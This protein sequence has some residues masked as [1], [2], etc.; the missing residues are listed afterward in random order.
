[1][2]NGYE[3][4]YREEDG[5][6]PKYD[7]R[8]SDKLAHNL[9]GS[10]KQNHL[11][12]TINEAYANLIEQNIGKKFY[13]KMSKMFS[14]YQYLYNIIQEYSKNKLLLDQEE[15]LFK[16]DYNH[17]K[18][19][20]N[21]KKEIETKIKDLLKSNKE[22]KSIKIKEYADKLE[23]LE[24]EIADVKISLKENETNLK[25][26]SRTSFLSTLG[27]VQNELGVYSQKYCD[28]ILKN[29]INQTKKYGQRA[30][31]LLISPDKKY[32]NY[33]D[34]KEFINIIK[35]STR[36]NDSV[37]INDS[38]KF[39]VYLQKTKLNGAYSVFERINNALGVDCGAN[40][41]VVEV[42][43]QK[44]EDI[45]QALNDAL[46]KASENTN[47]LIVASDFYAN[48]NN[49]V[50]APKEILQKKAAKN[51][52]NQELPAANTNAGGAFDKNSIKLFNQAYNR[53]VKVV[54]DPVFKKFSTALKMKRQDLVIN[55]YTGTKSLFSASSGN[56]CASLALEYNKI[57]QVIVRITIMEGEQKR[58]FETETVD[59]TIL[60][61]RKVYMMLSEL[62]DKFLLILKK[63]N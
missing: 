63:N 5:K 35:E 21:E 57:E 3:Y 9:D 4:L 60:D 62:I 2:I 34:P 30:C 59:F 25:I 38:D 61:Y 11:G 50:I 31:I 10:G 53:K 52:D 20:N 32:P 29:E 51:F 36:L 17:N 46:N 12:V 23:D 27:V 24:I 18:K 41:G 45:K 44:F 40:A 43:N 14:D 28:E 7:L 6:K 55:C 15:E 26:E 47:S 19:L 37:I 16:S 49:Q 48:K 1:M 22:K 39:Y 58:L 8:K 54:V 33:K 13:E 56:L 42:Q